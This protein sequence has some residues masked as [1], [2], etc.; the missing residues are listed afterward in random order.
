MRS[1]PV[2]G[3]RPA[4]VAATV[5]VLITSASQLGG[6]GSTRKADFYAIRNVRIG[7]MPG[8]GSVIVRAQPS[9]LLAQERRAMALGPRD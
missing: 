2:Q 5:V 7:S 3:N 8:D 1:N 6:C 4:L 9:S